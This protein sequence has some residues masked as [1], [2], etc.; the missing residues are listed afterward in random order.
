MILYKN[1][2]VVEIITKDVSRF[3]C[4]FIIFVFAYDIQLCTGHVDEVWGMAAHPSLAQFVTAG[5]DQLLQLWDALSHSTVWSKDIDVRTLAATNLLFSNNFISLT[6]S[7]V[8]K[9]NFLP[10]PILLY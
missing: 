7:T 3:W 1:I 4:A 5:R 10:K 2:V 9:M 6:S 8:E